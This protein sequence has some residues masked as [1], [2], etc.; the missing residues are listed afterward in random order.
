MLE[1]VQRVVRRLLNEFVLDDFV[2]SV[3]ARQLS[4]SYVEVQGAVRRRLLQVVGVI[5]V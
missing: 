2:G 4:H 5:E 1:L 3:N